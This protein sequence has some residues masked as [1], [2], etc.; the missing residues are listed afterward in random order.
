M[1]NAKEKVFVI[2]DSRLISEWNWEKNS[3]VSPSEVTVGSNKK[4][5]WIGTCG[6]SWI[7]AVKSRNIGRGCP[8]CAGGSLLKGFN[9]LQTIAPKIAEGWDIEKNHPILPSDVFS[10]SHAKVWWLCE[11]GHSWLASPNHRVSK[12][13]GCPFCCHNPK[14]LTNVNDFQTNHPDIAKEWHP[15]KNG[16][17]QPNQF[18]VNS[19]K[20]VWWKCVKGHEWRTSINHRSNGSNCPTCNQSMQTSFPEQAIY[21]YVK[22]AYPNSI[23]RYTDLFNNHG[24][25]LDIYI[26]SEKIG[27]EYDGSAFHRSKIINQREIHKYNICKNNGVFLVRIRED[28][29]TET[30]NICDKSIYLKSDLNSVMFDLIQFLPKLSQIEI[31]IE[32]DDAEIRKSYYAFLNCNSLDSFYPNLCDE[33]NHERNNGLTPNMFLPHSQVKVW[34][35]CSKNHEWKATIDSRSGGEGC[36]YCSNVKVLPGYNDLET[37]RPDLIT[38]W[39]FSKN[40]F[41]PSSVVPGSGKSAWWLC[42]K[43]GKSWSAEISSRNKGHGCP[44]CTRKIGRSKQINKM[45]KQNGSLADR[46]PHLAAEWHPHKNLGLLPN[47]VTEKSGKRVW[48]QCLI[49]GHEWETRI[50]DRSS[51]KTKCPC[52]SR[53]RRQ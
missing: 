2:D 37:M 15:T 9:D 10:N 46:A 42:S 12:G 30:S 7:A 44:S 8:Y 3:E 24:M 18:T 19:S 22:K 29:N 35:I 14:V 38:E 16:T 51:Y 13:R 25:E 39:D 32:K 26:P 1:G 48:W 17:L 45:I 4:V 47:Q 6:H 50:C 33:W 40:I 34:W 11:N 52:C 41:S 20:S 31:N 53:K 43:C 27:I 49:C 5:W 21:Y 23:N 36:P 28:N